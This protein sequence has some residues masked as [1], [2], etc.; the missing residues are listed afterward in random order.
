MD[1]WVWIVIALV[2]I[3]VVAGI[4]WSA[5]SSRRRSR[6]QEGFGPEYDRVVDD[7]PSRREAESELRERQ[8]RREEFDIRPLPAASRDR[9][10]RSWEAAQARFVDDP[11]GAVG[12]ADSL[13]QSVMRE[14]GY[15]VD[16]FDQ[17]SADLSVDH[18]DVV[19]HY[20]DGHA[21]ATRRDD[22]GDRTEA[23]RQA[24]VH[25]RVLFEELLVAE[26]A[27]DRMETNR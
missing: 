10:L 4:V 5:V 6:L 14:R 24:M 26:D 27:G 18:P 3:V 9:Y 15:P 17:R 11:E 1:T 7:A 22:G 16:D 23:Q 20:R 13:I 8:A 25:Y 2:A 19:E 12:E 21:L